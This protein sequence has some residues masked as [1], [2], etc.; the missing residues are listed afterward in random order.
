MNVKIKRID[1]EIQLPRY[2]TEG[3]VAFDL[4]AR[5]ETIIPPH[6]VCRIPMN[7]VIEVPKGYALLLALRS[8]TPKKKGLLSPHGV[9]IIDQDFCGEKDEI[10]LLVF[11]FTNLEVKVLRGERIAQAM[12]VKIERADFYEASAPMSSLSRG[13]FGSTG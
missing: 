5:E 9:G 8:S 3:S 1:P 2:G 4:C 11:N 7:V 10:Q 13:G 6:A 12:F